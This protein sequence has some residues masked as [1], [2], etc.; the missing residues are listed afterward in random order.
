MT[1]QYIGIQTQQ[2]RN[3][4]RSL[5]LL[6]LFPCLVIGLLYAFCYLLHVL[7][8]NDDNMTQAQLMNYSTDMFLHLAPYV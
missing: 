5:L 2:S 6:C 3:N 7:A 1:M 4:F 8:Y